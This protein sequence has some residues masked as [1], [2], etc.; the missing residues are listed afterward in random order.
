MMRYITNFKM[1]LYGGIPRSPPLVP[2]DRRMRLAAGQIP[3]L[4]VA[5]PPLTN[6]IISNYF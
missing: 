2:R 5:S 1:Y 6:P 3:G 4:H